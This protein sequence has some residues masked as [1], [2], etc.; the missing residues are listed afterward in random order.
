MTDQ[1]LI[2]QMKASADYLDSI[3][4]HYHA[5][6]FKAAIERLSKFTGVMPV[7]ATRRS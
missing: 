7:V 2:N 5:N 3:A 1:E 4:N 6:L